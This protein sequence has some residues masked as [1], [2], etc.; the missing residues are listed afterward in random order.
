MWFGWAVWGAFITFRAVSTIIAGDSSVATVFGGILGFSLVVVPL[1]I[2][3]TS[4]PTNAEYGSGAFW[5]G[6]ALVFGTVLLFY[7]II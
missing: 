1:Y 7:A 6:V 5:A 4:D 2:V 3:I